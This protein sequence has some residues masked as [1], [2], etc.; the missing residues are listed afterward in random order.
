MLLKRYRT[1]IKI[2]EEHHEAP[3]IHPSKRHLGIILTLVAL[4]LYS[5]YTVFFQID[6][7]KGKDIDVFYA[8]FF[9][10]TVF[11]FFAFLSFLPF[12]IIQGKAYFKCKKP[13][14]IIRGILA[15]ICIWFY[16]LS[17]IWT[18]DVDNSMLYSTDG[19]WVVILLCA[20]GFSV[21]KLVWV[22]SAI[23]LF[24]ILF[25]YFFDLRSYFDLLGGVFGTLSGIALSVIILL[26]RY[27]IR[28]DSPLRI[29]LYSNLIGVIMFGIPTVILGFSCGWVI[30][31]KNAIIMMMFSGFLFA[32][33][34]FCFLEAFYYSETY[35]I[36]ATRFFVPVFIQVIVWIITKDP[37]SWTTIIGSC[38]MTVGGI[39]III[40]AYLDDKKSTKHKSHQIFVP[41]I[42]DSVE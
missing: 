14:L 40:S 35:T 17:R 16:S 37:T 15:N 4:L 9:E 1:L 23:G 41:E 18:P 7:F 26:N 33:T 28:R 38:I 11:C 42:I 22:G 2:I 32:L 39:L 6:A 3:I 29:G 34:L 24:G 27:M 8:T 30:P 12:C 25:V 20:L 5:F 31:D 21:S 19:F 36:G 13:K 10:F